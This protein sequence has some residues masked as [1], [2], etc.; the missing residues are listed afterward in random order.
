MFASFQRII[1]HDPVS[2]LPACLEQAFQVRH[3]EGRVCLAGGPEIG[4]D[5]A[6]PSTPR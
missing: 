5:A 6:I 2:A 1:R 3:L 4:L